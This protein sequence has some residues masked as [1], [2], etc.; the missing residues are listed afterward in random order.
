MYGKGRMFGLALTVL[1]KLVACAVWADIHSLSS[2][3]F[4]M[5]AHFQHLCKYV[6]TLVFFH[7]VCVICKICKG[8]YHI[9]QKIWYFVVSSALVWQ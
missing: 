8:T 7:A 3:T 6:E 9:I 4:M 2:A 5:C 1:E